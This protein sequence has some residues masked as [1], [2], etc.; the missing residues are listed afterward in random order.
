MKKYV[1]IGLVTMFFSNIGL[2]A[3]AQLTNNSQELTQID[4]NYI[5]SFLIFLFLL[6]SIFRLLAVFKSGFLVSTIFLSANVCC[7]DV[8]IP[9]FCG[10]HVCPKCLF[11]LPITCRAQALVTLCCA[12][13]RVMALVRCYGMGYWST[14]FLMSIVFPCASII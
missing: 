2:N 11:N 9:F 1:I 3:Q 13:G 12:C 10:F 14:I 4:F 6:F 8:S 7:Y 5:Y